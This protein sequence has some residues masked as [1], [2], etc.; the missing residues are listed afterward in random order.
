MGSL[1]QRKKAGGPGGAAGSGAAGSEG[2]AAGPGEVEDGRDMDELMDEFADLRLEL[3][4]LA[5]EGTEHFAFS[6][7]G[8]KWT[9]RHKHVGG[10]SV[11]AAKSRAALVFVHTYSFQHSVSF[12]LAT[13]EMADSATMAS[14]WIHRMDYFFRIWRVT[15]GAFAFSED[16][17]DSYKETEEFTLFASKL[18]KDSPADQ[19]VQ[20]I[21]SFRPSKAATLVRGPKGK[22]HG[23]AKGPMPVGPASSSG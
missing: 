19:R 7:R 9:G 14:A 6:A 12:A 18:R 2:G 11:M 23:K 17:I 21:R 13:Y 3:A 5:G 16:M 22:G 10:D 15:K 8:G 20:Q 4:A 1:T